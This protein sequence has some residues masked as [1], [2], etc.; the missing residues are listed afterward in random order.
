MRNPVQS[1]FHV[2]C[3]SQMSRDVFVAKMADAVAAVSQRRDYSTVWWLAGDVSSTYGSPW[4]N[5]LGQ[6][7]SADSKPLLHLPSLD[8]DKPG[9]Q[10]VE[11]WF[12]FCGVSQDDLLKIFSTCDWT[13]PDVL[14]SALSVKAEH[15][16][17]YRR[18]PS[19][20]ALQTFADSLHEGI[21]V[22]MTRD[23]D[24]FSVSGTKIIV[25]AFLETFATG[26]AV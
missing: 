9:P 22:D 20:Q 14:L 7:L 2:D 17:E 12:S 19:Y 21:A 4:P 10:L 8:L 26:R 11:H 15:V 3:D 1:K 16:G 23:N 24:S 25:E 18:F 6:V 5:I 13:S